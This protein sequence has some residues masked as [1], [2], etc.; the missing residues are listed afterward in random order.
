[1]ARTHID[2]LL[3][4]MDGVLGVS[5]RPLPGAAAAVAKLRE[6]GLSLRVITSTTAKSRGDIGSGL[7][8]HGF[9]FADEDPLTASVLAAAYLRPASRRARHAGP[10]DRLDRRSAGLAGLLTPIAARRRL[11]SRPTRPYHRV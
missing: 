1:M 6:A 11:Y 8:E 10:H 4:D 9:D 5:W 3:L 7:R 2:G